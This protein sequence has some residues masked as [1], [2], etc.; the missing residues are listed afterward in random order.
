MR[1]YSSFYS[2]CRC[3]LCRTS[4]STAAV[5]KKHSFFLFFSFFSF[6]FCSTICKVATERSLR[7]FLSLFA[8]VCVRARHSL[9]CSHLLVI[10]FIPFL[11]VWAENIVRNPTETYETAFLYGYC[12]FN[13]ILLGISTIFN[14][15]RNIILM[16][17]NK[18]F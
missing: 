1:E 11:C 7:N 15:F 10:V 14:L 6:S 3:F 16:V 8:C 13:K 2:S 17:I 4:F 12:L 5:F 9:K 18:S